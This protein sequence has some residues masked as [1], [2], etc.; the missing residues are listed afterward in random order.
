MTL[1]GSLSLKL[2]FEHYTLTHPIHTK[3][4]FKSLTA[5]HLR[6][7][8]GL[9]PQL[10]KHRGFSNLFSSLYP[11]LPLTVFDLDKVSSHYW[12]EN[13]NQLFYLEK[14][15]ERVPNSVKQYSDWT[16]FDS[17]VLYDH[18]GRTILT[19]SIL[20]ILRANYP[21]FPWSNLR[22]SPGNISDNSR[23][24]FLDSFLCTFFPFLTRQSEITEITG[25][26]ILRY[27]G[28]AV[29]CQWSGSLQRVYP[30]LAT[31]GG[32]GGEEESRVFL[33]G[34]IRS[35][36]D[37]RTQ[38][39]LGGV[40]GMRL[41]GHP[42]GWT[43]LGAHQ[44]SFPHLISTAYPALSPPFPSAP[45]GYW[46]NLRE[47]DLLPRVLR[48]YAIQRKEDWYRL[49]VGQ[50]SAIYGRV[51]RKR[52]VL[53][54]FSVTYPEEEWDWVRFSEKLNRRSKQRYLGLK[55]VEGGEEEEGLGALQCDI[56]RGGV[57]L[58]EVL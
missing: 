16:F 38:E 54:L 22:K 51:V 37:V 55:L 6:D 10:S 8:H 39:E 53:E 19:T 17:E 2:S 52:R 13:R 56:P 33:D 43:L 7:I 29:V 15:T 32:P 25:N 35:W 47:I 30:E 23:R 46:S 44:G 34:L 49:S 20:D 40:P 42:G 21:T 50:F 26:E 41:V 9:S 28:G 14:L 5:R 27:S 58:G 24:L 4:D 12:T 31:G 18:H 3:H 36:Q 48:S 57:G 45:R 1:P 11:S